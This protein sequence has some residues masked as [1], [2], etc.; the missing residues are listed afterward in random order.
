MRRSFT[1]GNSRGKGSSLEFLP[2]VW[3]D[4]FVVSHGGILNSKDPQKCSHKKSVLE[5][6]EFHPSFFGGLILL[7]YRPS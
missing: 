5:T 2:D 6:Q 4:F 1:L 3:S 7:G